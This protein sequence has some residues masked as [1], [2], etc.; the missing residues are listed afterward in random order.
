MRL[1]ISGIWSTLSKSRAGERIYPAHTGETCRQA[2][3][4]SNLDL[5]AYDNFGLHLPGSVLQSLRD[6]AE[7]R[8][9]NRDVLLRHDLISYND[10]AR[11]NHWQLTK[12]GKLP[13]GKLSMALFCDFQ[14]TLILARHSELE[15]RAADVY[16]RPTLESVISSKLVSSAEHASARSRLVNTDGMDINT[17]LAD[18][19]IYRAQWRRVLGLTLYFL[20]I[21]NGQYHKIGVTARPMSERLAEIK[22]DLMPLIGDVP[23]RVVDTFEHRGAAELYFK[24][25]FTTNTV[26]LGALTEYYH[27]DDPKPV[28]TELRRMRSKTLSDLEQAIIAGQPAA[29]ERQIR[30]DE[31]EAKRRSAIV[32]GMERAQSRGQVIGRPVTFDK[33]FL[34]RYQAV[35]EALASGLSLRKIAAET[36]VAINTVRKVQRL[37]E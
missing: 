2:D 35:A 26:T 16:A 22:A 27:F 3:R 14:E 24:H 12:R 4:D 29:I 6:F 8:A 30:R 32:R 31:T 34:T 17:A 11:V 15:A 5:P 20:D 21:N 23:V 19:R 18:L 37:I 7:D 10:F 36:G 28:I 9:T 33:A 1:T 13:L 25:R